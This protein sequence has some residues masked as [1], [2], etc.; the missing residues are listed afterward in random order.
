[1]IFGDLESYSATKIR[2]QASKIVFCPLNLTAPSPPL[3][4]FYC[5]EVFSLNYRKDWTIRQT[6][7]TVTAGWYF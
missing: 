2:T 5:D 4:K 6:A 1:L 7:I 3:L